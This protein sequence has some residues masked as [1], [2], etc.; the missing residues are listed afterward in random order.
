MVIHPLC[1]AL[2]IEMKRSVNM[3]KRTVDRHF[4]EARLVCAYFNTNTY[5]QAK[6]LNY[7]QGGL[8]FESELAFRPGTNIY[9]R[10]EEFSQEASKSPFHN[11]FRTTTLGE[12]KWCKE[13][14]GAKS[15]KFGIGVK[16]YEPY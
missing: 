4:H 15:C 10:I 6:M 16:Y 7:C 12:V 1:L 5:Y 13:I 8:Y 9:I 3:E 11:G 2:K 14:S